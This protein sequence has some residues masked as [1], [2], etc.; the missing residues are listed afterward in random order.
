M[1]PFTKLSRYIIK[2]YKKNIKARPFCELWINHCCILRYYYYILLS[3]EYYHLLWEDMNITLNIV[4]RK[5]YNK[6]ECMIF[7]IQNRF[8][9]RKTDIRVEEDLYKW[10]CDLLTKPE[11]KQLINAFIPII[12]QMAHKT[13]LNNYNKINILNIRFQMK[14]DPDLI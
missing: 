3:S 2:S 6:W 14:D 10:D 11:I 12:N 9:I 4:I 5:V 13:N 7:I 1:L 8:P